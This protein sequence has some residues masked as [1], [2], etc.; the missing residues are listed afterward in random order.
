MAS[1]DYLGYIAA[2]FTTFA[3]LPQIIKAWKTR[4]TK[5][6]SLEMYLLT[7][8]GVFIWLVYGFLINNM[9][10]IIANTISL[11]LVAIMVTL[12]LR[13]K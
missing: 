3:T 5:D 12:K 7:G 9:P 10:L 2:V 6:I 1:L 8:I 11:I 4:R 13:Y